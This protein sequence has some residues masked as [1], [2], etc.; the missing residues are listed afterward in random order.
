VTTSWL[1]A[2]SAEHALP[3]HYPQ[4]KAPKRLLLWVLPMNRQCIWLTCC[5]G[6]LV[7]RL[8]VQLAGMLNCA[9]AIILSLHILTGGNGPVTRRDKRSQTCSIPSAGLGLSRADLV[10]DLEA[11]YAGADSF[12]SECHFNHEQCLTRWSLLNVWTPRQC[13]SKR[14]ALSVASMRRK[15]FVSGH[16]SHTALYHTDHIAKVD[17]S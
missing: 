12:S 8:L 9:I 15:A 6:P 4:T 10:T 11:M 2:V 13:A 16:T 14:C 1:S 7:L 5:A 17:G 3:P